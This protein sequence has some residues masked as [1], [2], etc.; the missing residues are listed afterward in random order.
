MRVGLIASLAVCLAAC[1]GGGD[2]SPPT[3]GQVP[4]PSLTPTPTPTPPPP[5][6]T[7]FQAT[8]GAPLIAGV[9]F[10]INGNLNF[11]DVGDIFTETN[12]RGE[13]GLN[14]AGRQSPNPPP[15]TSTATVEVRGV[16]AL[17]GFRYS[18][19]RSPGG[20]AIH[21]PITTLL[22]GPS[23]DRTPQN[24]GLSIN[25]ETL[26]TFYA[27]AALEQGGPNVATAR[28][29]I[30]TDLKLLA[31]AGFATGDRAFSTDFI[32]VHEIVSA[33]AT[34]IESGPVDL[35]SS[36]DL[37]RI[38]RR[39]PRTASLT[40]SARAAATGLLSRFGEVVDRH[41]TN[42]ASIADIE[43]GL[44]I[45]I[46]PELDSLLPESFPAGEARIA[47]IDVDTILSRFRSYA[48]IPRIN[49]ESGVLAAVVDYRELVFLNSI[50]LPARCVDSSALT[51]NDLYLDP[52]VAINV[53]DLEVTAVRVPQQF[54]SFLTAERL[55]DGSVR[56][57]R[58]TDE[59]TLVWFDYDVRGP[60]GAT[61]SS[62][63]YVRLSAA[64]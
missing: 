55:V 56:L 45:D 3:G 62:R 57:T 35:N 9:T 44:R 37:D 63:A 6:A 41:L 24:L 5:E 28:R 12:R 16:S 51:C 27:Y 50:T 13:F 23:D 2:S 18:Q 32:R 52:R 21:S 26:L 61:A 34:E 64:Q 39:L 33:L 54:S 8:M 19:I 38:L 43:Y 40:P 20:G 29:V 47:A 49:A 15:A 10:D 14:A 30:A 36:T 7:P 1:G 4:M 58:H 60:D 31:L 22:R 25:A 59:R 11:G 17:T 42:A 48:A 46:L 53:S